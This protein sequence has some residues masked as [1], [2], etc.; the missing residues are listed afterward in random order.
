MTKWLRENLWRHTFAIFMCV[1]ALFPLYLV[2]LS[3]FNPTGSL[4]L[5]SFIPREIS[6]ENYKMLFSSPKIPFLSWVKNSLIIASAVAISSVVIGAASAFAFSRLKFKGK[7]FGIQLLLLVQINLGTFS[8]VRNHG[9]CVL[10]RTRYWSRYP[11]RLDP[12]LSRR[13]N[14][15]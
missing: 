12:R 14:G 13:I 8:G 6:F 4:N 9:T 11:S 5:T 3:S 1:F 7:K 2:V 10:I 15:R